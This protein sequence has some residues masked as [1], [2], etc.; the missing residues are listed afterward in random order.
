MLPYALI[1]S[2]AAAEA[3]DLGSQSVGGGAVAR[4]MPQQTR[5][6][7][8]SPVQR[9]RQRVGSLLSLLR[10]CQYHSLYSKGLLIMWV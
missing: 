3:L 6:D 7:T 10:F 2:A 5:Q 4:W 8:S 1:F 9:R